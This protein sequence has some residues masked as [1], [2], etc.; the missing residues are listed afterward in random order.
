MGQSITK[1]ELTLLRAKV[2]AINSLQEKVELV[3][4][5][6]YFGCSNK[7]LMASLPD[8][9]ECR[10]NAFEKVTEA[11]RAFETDQKILQQKKDDQINILRSLEE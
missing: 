2:E 4:S 6:V 10:K 9:E 3:W 11:Y 7:K 8:V 5:F 1:K